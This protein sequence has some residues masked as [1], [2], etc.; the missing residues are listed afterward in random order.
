MQPVKEA[1]RQCLASER[2]PRLP[3]LQHIYENLAEPTSSHRILQQLTQRFGHLHP[4]LPQASPEGSRQR[5]TLALQDKCRRCSRALPAVRSPLRAAAAPAAAPAATPAPPGP[6]PELLAPAPPTP[7]MT[8]WTCDSTF[9][10]WS[11]RR[12]ASI[13]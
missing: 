13:N 9:R 5:V 10:A 1:L 7:G 3:G 11:G 2:V 4:Q 12:K 8:C 6:S